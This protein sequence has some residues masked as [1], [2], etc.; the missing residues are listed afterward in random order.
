[1]T[2]MS[3]AFITANK[4]ILDPT[5]TGY[6]NVSGGFHDAGDHVKFGLPQTYSSSTLEWSLYEFKDAFVQ[7]GEFAHMKEVLRWFSDYFLRSTFMNSTG[8]VVA[9]CYQVGEGSIDHTLWAPPEIISPAVIKRPGYFATSEKP[10]SD[11]CAGAAASLALSYLNN[12]TDD[13]TYATKCLT[14]AKAL[15]DFAVLNRGIGYD[16]G[17]Y[18]SSYDADELSWAAIWLYSATNDSK[19]L[20]DIVSKDANGMYTGWLSK[21]IRSTADNWQNMWVNSWDTKWAGVFAKL[22]QITNDPFY[23]YIFR[24]NLEFWSGVTHQNPADGGYL[25][26]T[27][28][29]FSYISTWGSARY[30]AAAQ[31]LALMYKKYENSTIF[32]N[33]TI[34]QMQYIMG[35]NPLNRSYIV[36]YSNSAKHPHHRAA[37]GSPNNDMSN[38]AQ[39]KH[40]L[41]GALVGGPATDDTHDDAITDYVS[42]EVAIDYNAGL[43]GSLAGLYTYFGQGQLPIANFYPKDSALTEFWLKGKIEQD[44]NQRSQITIEVSNEAAYPPRLNVAMVARYFFNITE[45]K[46]YN[47]SI[48][49]VSFSVNY[50]ENVTS[51]SGPVTAVGPLA[52]D[53]ANNVYYMEFRWPQAG[54]YGKRDY[55]FAL[56]AGM[57]PVNY[58]FHWDPTNDYSHQGLS[59]SALTST[60][61]IS[62][63][64]D[65]KLISGIEP[66]IG[67]PVI[68]TGVTVTPTTAAINTGA[69]SQLTATVAPANSTNKNVTWKSSNTTVATVSGTGLVTG[70]AAGSATITVTTADGSKT[71]TCAVTVSTVNNAVTGVTVTPATSAVNVAGTVQLTATVAPANATNKNV[72]WSSSSTAIATVSATGL[73]TGVASGTSTITVTTV[74]GLKTA[75]CVVTVSIGNIAVTGVTVSPTAASVLVG[76]TTQLTAAVAPANATNKVVSWSS[77]STTI[78]TVSSTGLVTALSVGTATITVTTTDGLKTA[79]SVITVSTSN[80]AVTGVSVAPATA[81][82]NVGSTSQLTAT[83]APANATNKN[84]TWNSSSTA[85]ATVS[86]TG[87]VTG[88]ANGTAT[89]TATTADGAKTSIC[90]VTVS[91]SSTTCGFGTPL[92]TALP[93]INKSYTYVYLLGTGGP[94]LSNVSTFT[95]NWDLPN[96]GLYQFSVNTKDGKPNWYVDLRT[97]ATQTFASVQPS[98]TLAGSGFTGLDGSYYAAADNGNLVLVSKTAG[99]TLYFS[100]SATVPTCV[101]SAEVTGE[102]TND[103]PVVLYPNPFSEYATIHILNPEKVNAVSIIDPL[104]RVLSKLTGAQIT[105]QLE[106][107]Q[108]LKAGIYFVKIQTVKGEQTIIIIKK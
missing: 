92:L 57:D 47:Q 4:G 23:L 9:F 52:W 25:T 19:Y 68:V 66:P 71:A 44:N 107:G 29:G 62:L 95:I 45:L 105:N 99:F 102:D 87:L 28:A 104:G 81:S 76:A 48:S 82:V 49:D 30:N 2:N 77:S 78:A 58:V 3:D 24:W 22:A 72:T 26:K 70:V 53:A 10:A 36:G 59:A 39:H 16:G 94:N 98:V 32:D 61:N 40:I 11:Q 89:I 6:V 106:V 97:G 21:I 100:N 1:M 50:D 86:S 64:A 12:T 96:K 13:P 41:Y 8:Q 88:V 33:W 85:V 63:Y 74:D 91:T 7:T 93:T 31:L 73:V 46:Q 67:T 60:N 101:K 80:V 37:H 38:P 55:Q 15:Y 83:I 75:T 42:N 103:Q 108:N 43:V 34:S 5:G 56:V 51:G 20:N 90:A 35:K 54:F 14:T 79:T 84:V 18:Q 69:T 27:P 17:F 65:G